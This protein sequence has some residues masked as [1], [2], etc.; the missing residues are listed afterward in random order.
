MSEPSRSGHT[1][2]RLLIVREARPV[3]ELRIRPR[4]VRRALGWFFM[5]AWLFPLGWMGGTALHARLERDALAERVAHLTQQAASLSGTIAEFE[6][7]AGV[8]LT[9]ASD[10]SGGPAGVALV[11]AFDA[12]E[13]TAEW[14]TG[15][16]RRFESASGILRDRMERARAT[17]TGTP[18]DGSY[19]SSSF[20]WRANPFTGRG[21]EWHAGLDFPAP[22]GTPVKATADGVV[23][24]VGVNGGYG[25]LIVVR[26]VDGYT[27]LFGHLRK[28]AVSAG[29][30]VTRGMVV[31]YVGSGGR[32]T[33]PHVHYEVRRHGKPVN[34]RRV[35]PIEPFAPPAPTAVGDQD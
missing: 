17:P 20:G 7:Y 26:H 21:S 4:L 10:N 3:K 28:S 30:S 34:P 32:S 25:L 13:G 9:P 6:R 33:G 2:I 15:L 27:T 1:P 31:G 24:S 16:R 18:L 35:R 11:E 19:I 22:T 8:Q 14:L 23:Q 12:A 29:D 5:V